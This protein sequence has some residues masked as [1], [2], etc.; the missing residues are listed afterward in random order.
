MCFDLIKE[1]I[2]DKFH[3]IANKL[4]I[5]AD[6]EDQID[7]DNTRYAN[8]EYDTSTQQSQPRENSGKRLVGKVKSN[9][10]FGEPPAYDSESADGKWLKNI[11]DKPDSAGSNGRKSDLKTSDEKR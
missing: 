1:G 8:F 7:E 3:W 9:D 4:G 6:D 2:V 10:S 11:R 5:V